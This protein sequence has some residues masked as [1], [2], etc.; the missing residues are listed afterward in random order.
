MNTHFAFDLDGTV[1]QE[2][3]LPR[4][5]SAVGLEREM[6][7]LTQLTLSGAIEFE[8]S[9]R[10][11]CAILNALP[12]SVVQDAVRDAEL[13]P[14]IEMFIRSNRERCSIVTGNLD[15]WIEPLV[16]RLGCSVFSSTSVV[17]G[18]KLVRVGDVMHKSRPL[19]ELRK[20]RLK[21]VAIG[22]S[23]NDMPMFE[24]ADI[25]VA[26]GGVHA[27][28]PAL[29]GI[30]DYVVFDGEALCRLLNTL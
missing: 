13:N 14:S 18:D 20:T 28:A 22:D 11:R 19:L 10:L 23:V 7:L 8:D 9:F 6:Q 25:G 17:E 30:S 1:T 5:A 2:E 3:L 21:L 26:F 29:V 24:S 4:I 15:V 12:I 27:P 16:K